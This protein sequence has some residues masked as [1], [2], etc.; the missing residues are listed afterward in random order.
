MLNMGKKV[1]RKTYASKG[2]RRSIGRWAVNAVRRDKPEFE[3][4]LNKIEAWR[5]GKNPW[6]TVPGSS[7]NMRFIK[8]RANSVY[9]NPKNA[10]ANIY[11]N[12]G[13]E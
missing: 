11:G 8:V 1:K 13:E 3:K 9:G 5:A 7:S 6:I 12:K 2:E 10:S 4:A